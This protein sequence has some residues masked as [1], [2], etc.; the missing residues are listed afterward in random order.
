MTVP[1]SALKRLLPD[2]PPACLPHLPG[3]LAGDEASAQAFFAGLAP[4]R[5]GEMAVALYQDGLARA[6]LRVAVTAAWEAGPREFGEAAKGNRKALGIISACVFPPALDL[7]ASVTVWR[8]TSGL[9]R[10]DAE[11]GMSWSLSRDAACWH[12]LQGVERFGPPVVVRRVL[13]RASILWVRQDRGQVIEVVPS[14][15]GLADADPDPATWAESAARYAAR[16]DGN[17]SR[18]PQS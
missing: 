13:R 12:A 4:H 10:A 11:T 3:L 7:A 2:L 18:E 1:G 5:R 17:K 8:G 9:S 16:L 15:P 14:R 6:S